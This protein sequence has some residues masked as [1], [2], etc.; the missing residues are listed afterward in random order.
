MCLCFSTVWE[1]ILFG[2]H[3]CNSAGCDSHNRMD[4]PY[5]Y[6]TIHRWTTPEWTVHWL[7]ALLCC[8]YSV[9]IDFAMA[10]HLKYIGCISQCFRILKVNNW[11]LNCFW[12][13]TFI[14]VWPVTAVIS[15]TAVTI[16]SWSAVFSLKY[17]PCCCTITVCTT[18]SIISTAG[19]TSSWSDRLCLHVRK[20]CSMWWRKK[21]G[22]PLT[23]FAGIK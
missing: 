17:W 2:A 3:F 13:R 10:V 5:E 22:Q 19:V 12:R 7:K 8:M 23:H 15:L 11:E 6:L 16:C 21:E 18:E 1:K 20:I 9:G 14:V 4:V